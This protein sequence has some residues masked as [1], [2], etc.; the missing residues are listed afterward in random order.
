MM[1][2]RFLEAIE[3]L[4]VY[5]PQ[6]S[7]SIENVV[8]K[9]TTSDSFSKATYTHA[10]DILTNYLL[11]R[12]RLIDQN[13]LTADN[14]LPLDLCFDYLWGACFFLACL[15]CT[16]GDFE[17]T[18]A[19]F[20]KDLL[21]EPPKAFAVHFV[22]NHSTETPR[23]ALFNDFVFKISRTLNWSFE[24]DHLRSQ[25]T[26]L[27]MFEHNCQ[28]LPMEASDFPA[29]WPR[30]VL[31]AIRQNKEDCAFYR[32]FVQRASEATKMRI[33]ASLLCTDS[34]VSTEE[35]LS[36]CTGDCLWHPPANE[37]NTAMIRREWS[38]SSCMS[39]LSTPPSADAECKMMLTETSDM[40]FY[41]R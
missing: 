10:A 30:T 4:Y 22:C 36:Y 12:K 19:H 20:A 13:D 18:T 23:T 16:N 33:M 9:C 40:P 7:Q 39:V 3:R 24:F 37:G 15:N 1:L 17:E 32:D 31:A 8:L 41:G 27:E 26:L 14:E 6:K 35:Y 28:V 11:A 34:L 2:C 5:T 25:S 38:V 29:D 21:P